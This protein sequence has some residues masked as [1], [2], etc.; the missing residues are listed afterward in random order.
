M[1]AEI[2]VHRHG[3][4]VLEERYLLGEEETEVWDAPLSVCE[5]LAELRTEPWFL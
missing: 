5:L 2:C 4:T 1:V 3:L